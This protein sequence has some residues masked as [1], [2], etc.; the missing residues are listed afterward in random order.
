MDL[1][2]R[3]LRQ[4]GR[5]VELYTDRHGIFRAEDQHGEATLTQFHGPVR[6]WAS[7]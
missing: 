3:Y 4:Q 1:T 2:R 6:S 7:S 5:P